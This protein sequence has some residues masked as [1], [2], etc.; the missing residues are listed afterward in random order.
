VKDSGLRLKVHPK[1]VSKLVLVL[2]DVRDDVYRPY[3]LYPKY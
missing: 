2:L 3:T 1:P